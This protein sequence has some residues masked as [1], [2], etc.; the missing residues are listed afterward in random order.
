[1]KTQIAPLLVAVSLL[2]FA[3]SGCVS[4]NFSMNDAADVT[5][6]TAS[7]FD[8]HIVTGYGTA[9]YNKSEIF[10]QPN[11]IISA[12]KYGETGFNAEFYIRVTEGDAARIR[13]R[14]EDVGKSVLPGICLTY[15]KEGCSIDAPDEPRKQLGV[16][17]IDDWQRVQIY[18]YGD[19]VKVKLGCDEVYT[20]RTNL[21]S[22]DYLI[23]ESV[24]GSEAE[25]TKLRS[26]GIE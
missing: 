22:T 25:I 26:Q 2:A 21:H 6:N 13:V 9:D 8:C 15:A 16:K 5:Q 4:D 10:I 24:D 18:S 20:T 7:S 1:M 17:A 19:S 14:S 11:S 23:F 12:R 3:V